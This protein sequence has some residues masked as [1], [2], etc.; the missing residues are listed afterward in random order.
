[1][2]K[3]ILIAVIT[4]GALVTFGPIAQAAE[5]DAP[6]QKGKGRADRLETMKTELKLTDEQVTKLKPIMDAD[7]KAMREVT[8]DSN[9]SR[10]ERREKMT[11][12]REASAPKIKAILTKE[13]ADKWE[14]LTQE[15]MKKAKKAP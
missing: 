8:Q 6:A 11:K 1:M 9:L 10:E 12:I 3:L 4:L 2:K 7:A 13:Q 5:G 14:K 15:R